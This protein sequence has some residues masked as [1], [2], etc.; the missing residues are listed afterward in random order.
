MSIDEDGM[1][2]VPD[3]RELGIEME[4]ERPRPP[5][6]REIAAQEIDE[7]DYR[8]VVHYQ[9]LDPD[10]DVGVVSVGSGFSLTLQD[11]L[12][13]YGL[14]AFDFC[15]CSGSP[16]A[17]KVEASVKLVF[18]NPKI[19]GFLFMSGV[20]TQDLTVT[21]EGIIDAYR[22]LEP[23]IPFIVRLAGNRDREAHAML[24]QAGIQS[25]RR[26]DAPEACIEE[27]KR[28]MAGVAQPAGGAR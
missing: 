14:R 26:E 28:Q 6:E 18:S 12:A 1:F 20:V 11:M 4:E 2:K 8:G 3:L 15:D 24:E 13:H 17:H 9:D 25:Y 23:A 7:E 10:G 22:A 19:R 16:P 27:L 21:A 5:T